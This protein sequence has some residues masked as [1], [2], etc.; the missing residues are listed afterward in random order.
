MLVSCLWRRP[1]VVG[2]K[3]APR[4]DV[5]VESVNAVEDNLVRTCAAAEQNGLQGPNTAPSLSSIELTLLSRRAIVLALCLGRF[6]NHSNKGWSSKELLLLQFLDLLF[7]NIP[8]GLQQPSVA[9]A[10]TANPAFS[11]VFQ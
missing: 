3:F 6:N 11:C 8:A 2:K 10:T 4:E 5:K 1:T 7:F 9:A